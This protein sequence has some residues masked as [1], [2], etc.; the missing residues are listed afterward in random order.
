MSFELDCASTMFVLGRNER[1]NYLIRLS[2][3]L[4]EPIEKET[5]QTAVERTIEKYPYFFIRFAYEQNRLVAKQAKYIPRVREKANVFCLKPWKGCENCEAQVTYFHKTIFLEFFHAVTDGKGGMEFLMYLTA[6]YLSLRYHNENILHSVPVI[7]K[8][9]QTENGYRKYAQGFRAKKSHGAAYQIKG[10]PAPMAISSYRLSA[11][12]IKQT[13]NKYGVSVTEFMAALL[14][15]AL[16]NIQ[17]RTCAV[18]RRKKIRL[19]VPVNLRT[20]FHCNTTRNFTLNVCPEL[21]PAEA[22]DLSGICMKFHQYM[23]TATEPEQLAGQC[24]A[25][26]TACDCGLV[27]ILPVSVKKW[28]VQTALDLPLASSSMTFSNMGAAPWPEELKTHVDELEL[29]FSPKPK[30]PYSC[31]AI[32]VNDKMRLIFLRTVKEPM[33]EAQLERLLRNLKIGFK[34]IDPSM[35]KEAI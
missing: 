27:K 13:A 23:K 22:G 19:L 6:E 20:R 25:A 11:C 29:T 21:D 18:H 33:L 28:L 24:A 16:S 9:K 32:T 4:H 7:P 5:L 35:I 26:A 30:A 31:S 2:A 1:R 17:K 12:E 14:C 34:K 15:T 10:T 3:T 8:D